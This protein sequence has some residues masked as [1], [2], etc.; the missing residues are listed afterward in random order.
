MAQRVVLVLGRPKAG[1]EAEFESWYANHL[2]EVARVPG[3][4][5]ARRFR[6]L[7]REE[8]ESRPPYS[9]LAIYEVACTPEQFDAACT[10]AGRRGEITAGDALAPGSLIWWFE[11]R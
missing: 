3:V 10:E 4:H 2:E 5:A 11:E 8:H 9:H 1:Q 6:H 7:Q